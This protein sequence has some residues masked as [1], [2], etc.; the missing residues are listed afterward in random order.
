MS[1]ITTL[2]KLVLMTKACVPTAL[3]LPAASVA[4]TETELLPLALSP[5]M[6]LV[7]TAV[8]VLTL[9]VPLV[10]VTVYVA[11]ATTTVMLAPTS[12]VPLIIGVAALVKAVLLITGT[13][14]A[15]VSTVKLCTLDAVLT[16]PS[17][18]V[19]LAMTL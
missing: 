10:A 18:S 9:Q 2:G 12:A 6:P 8:A 11:P 16:L 15:T 4:V 13:S 3:T 14:G 7:G 17:A 5:K 19:A 1:V